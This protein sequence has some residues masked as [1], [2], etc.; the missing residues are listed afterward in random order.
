MEA[1]GRVPTFNRSSSKAILAWRR[2]AL[3]ID[4]YR[5][6]HGWHHAEIGIG[7]TPIEPAARRTH[8]R[9]ERAIAQVREERLLRKDGHLRE[10]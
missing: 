8:A 6:E 7:P 5:N 2:A 3:A 10:R 1:I 4:D 9:I